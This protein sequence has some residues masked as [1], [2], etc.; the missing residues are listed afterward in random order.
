MNRKSSL[1]GG[2]T[3]DVFE[4]NREHGL[5]YVERMNVKAGPL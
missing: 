4:S 5:L 2:S 3:D 1:E